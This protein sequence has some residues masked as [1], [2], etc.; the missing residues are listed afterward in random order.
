VHDI[1]KRLRDECGASITVMRIINTACVVRYNF[2]CRAVIYHLCV[3]HAVN[4]KPSRCTRTQA[5]L[6][7]HNVTWHDTFLHSLLIVA[8]HVL[9]T[10]PIV[11]QRSIVTSVS[12][13]LGSVCTPQHIW[14][15]TP[16]NLIIFYVR[17]AV[18]GRGSRGLP[19]AALQN[20]MY[21]RFCG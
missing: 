5:S 13:C 19:L 2:R 6:Y 1:H 21:F 12:V 11:G 8:L 15:T 17:V 18:C 16:P 14:G 7:R 3:F 9:V 4:K 10:P 20:V